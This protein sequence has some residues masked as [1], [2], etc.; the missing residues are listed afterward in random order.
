MLRSRVSPRVL[1]NRSLGEAGHWVT[2]LRT[3]RLSLEDLF[4]ELTADSSAAEA[5]RDF[6]EVGR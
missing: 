6:V 2:E 3:E 5:E 1:P 4:L